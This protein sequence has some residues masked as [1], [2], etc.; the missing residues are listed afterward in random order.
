MILFT[1]SFHQTVF[2][3]EKQ[4]IIV[5][6]IKIEMGILLLQLFDLVLELNIISLHLKCTINIQYIIIPNN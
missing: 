3:H 6:C 1:H 4:I 2:L 5:N